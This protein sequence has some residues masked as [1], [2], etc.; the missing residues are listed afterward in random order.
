MSKHILALTLFLLAHGAYA[1]ECNSK[2]PEFQAKGDDYFIIEPIDELLRDDR[3]TIDRINDILDGKWEGR[4]TVLECRGSVSQPEVRTRHAVIEDYEWIENSRYAISMRMTEEYDG[5]SRTE[6]LQLL[7]DQT[8]TAISTG[9]RSV[10]V[11]EKYRQQ[12]R[13]GGVILV[14][15]NASV[16]ASARRVLIKI[17]QYT[18]G[19]TAFERTIELFR[20]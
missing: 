12:T 8:I 15:L 6:S 17:K 4:S 19:F 3:D 1:L 9:E 5:G 16:E 13:A 7:G 20:R 10:S 14:E 2:S 11:V 18:N